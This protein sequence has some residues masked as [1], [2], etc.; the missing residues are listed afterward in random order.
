MEFPVIKPEITESEYKKRCDFLEGKQFTL[1]GKPAK[2]G[3]LRLKFVTVYNRDNSA[4]FAWQ[5]VE[6]V[7]NFRGEFRTW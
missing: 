5:T 1:D 4:E 7:I 2:I 3:G 6:R